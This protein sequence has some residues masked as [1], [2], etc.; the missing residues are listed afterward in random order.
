[1]TRDEA[2]EWGANKMRLLGAD[3]DTGAC[4]LI[5][6]TVA[7]I[8]DNGKLAGERRALSESKLAMQLMAEALT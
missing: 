5:R 3:Q 1:M 8:Y 6:E 2:I 4:D 7:L